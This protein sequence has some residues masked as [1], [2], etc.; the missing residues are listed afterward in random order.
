MPG[1]AVVN[2]G[3]LTQPMTTLIEKVSDAVGGIAEPYQIVRVA[4]AEAKADLIRA[5]SEIE[6]AEL[7]FR[8]LHRFV[9]E[10]SRNQ[11]NM[12]DIVRMAL[13]HVED[14]ASPENMDDDW[15]TNFFEKSRIV[16]DEDMQELWARV[17]AGEANNP[18]NFSRKTIN[19]LHDMDKQSAEL[20]RTLCGYVWNIHSQNHLV[21][22]V[23]GP[24][25]NI[26]ASQGI[27]LQRLIDL[28]SLGLVDVDYTD[29]FLRPHLPGTFNA[30]Y[31]GRSVAL[32]LS[33]SAKGNLR[34]GGV[35]VTASGGQLASICGAKPAA[36]FFEFVCSKWKSDP[37]VESVRV[38]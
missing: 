34:I 21:V 16:S 3:G 13:R 11:L 17:L 26:Y 18:G 28:Q 37:S 31:S 38:L 24:P 25:E 10:E 29:G 9:A 20:F 30:S 2:V 35:T 12:E 4:R 23:Q 36:G 1:N 14:G 7:R 15:I 8:A 33:T 19:I 6:I 27:T 5:E 22:F 32:S